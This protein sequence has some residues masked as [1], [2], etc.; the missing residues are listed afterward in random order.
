MEYRYVYMVFFFF[1]TQLFPLAKRVLATIVHS[2]MSSLQY[3][4]MFSFCKKKYSSKDLRY[5]LKILDTFAL[6]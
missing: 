3:V 2:T 5:N 4:K 1:Y 6:S